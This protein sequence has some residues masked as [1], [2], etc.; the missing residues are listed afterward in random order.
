[1]MPLSARTCSP[2][3]LPVGDLHVEG[4]SIFHIL[5][6]LATAQEPAGRAT[7]ATAVRQLQH[8]HRL[9]ARHARRGLRYGYLGWSSLWGRRDDD[10]LLGDIVKLETRQHISALA[11]RSSRRCP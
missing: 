10:G 1:M 9:A 8:A 7:A 4:V 3:P 5:P 2:R 6:S 11:A